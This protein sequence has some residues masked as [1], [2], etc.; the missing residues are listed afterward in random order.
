MRSD[1]A[2][3]SLTQALRRHWR[4]AR[5]VFAQPGRAT[6][7]A[8]GA[9]LDE[10][11]GAM[12][13]WA[14]LDDRALLARGVACRAAL[15]RAARLGAPDAAARRAAALGLI[16]LAAGRHLG[17]VPSDPQLFAALAMHEG[18]AVD[19]PP[20]GGKTLAVACCAIL[21]AWSGTPC[22]VITATEAL[23]QR[24]THALARLYAMTG[25]SVGW[26]AADTPRE[27]LAELHACD[28][29]YATGRQLLADHIRGRA[30]AGDGAG[31]LRRQLR[32]MA[33]GA[34]S[35][36][37]AAP[38]MCAA[39]VD[40][41]DRVLLD[42]ALAPLVISAAGD[43]AILE[44][45]SQAAGALVAGLES[46]RD[47]RID[48]LPMA[49]V[50]FTEDGQARLQALRARL[51][52]FWRSPA[53]CEELVSNALLARD[54]LHKDSHYALR[55][56]AIVPL[57]D[58]LQALLG[59]RGWHAGILQA[60]EAREGVAV[61]PPPRTIART[62]FQ[63]FFP[64]YRSLCGSGAL[65]DDLAP[66]LWRFYRLA[67]VAAPQRRVQ[68]AGGPGRRVYATRRDKIEALVACAGALQRADL[69]VL[70]CAAD[71]ADLE[72]IA[73]A[74]AGAQLPAQV[75][76]GLDLEQDAV[77]VARAATAGALTVATA[78]ALRG[79]PIAVS[80]RLQA[81]GGLQL[82]M[83]G[84]QE[85]RRLDLLIAGK[86]GA[87]GPGPGAGV[88]VSLEDAMFARS[89]PLWAA[90]LHRLA[91]W[92][93]VRAGLTAWMVR[94]A[95]LHT[96]RQLARHRALLLKREQQLDQQLAFSRR[97]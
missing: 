85:L 96:G 29:L 13:Q 56:G 78:A 44:G 53:R 59:N 10:V 25:C 35:H 27:R 8:I 79:T 1:H 42:E 95:Q 14:A 55:D 37:P 63:E 45:A 31:P 67:T 68:G 16:A 91:R 69:P 34:Q 3:S 83:S 49:E 80:E 4:D 51:P 60:L 97:A 30:M 71:S 32:T 12:A 89:L 21:H 76:V 62:A 82:L 24:D 47:Y 72:A 9:Q 39:V 61:T 36:V 46:G 74:L 38:G 92:A 7:A 2:P 48:F 73:A 81:Q 58:K 5:A 15:T 28:V 17:M 90:P 50:G 64:L 18:Y 86:A 65:L 19:L 33:H 41:I 57:G 94:A 43:D 40:D 87:P 54:V 52:A 22:H 66:E 23:A 93:P 77:R 70:I 6:A 84:H 26:L 20:G 11:R 75:A 88:F